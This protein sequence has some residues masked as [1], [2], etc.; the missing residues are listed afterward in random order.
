MD[1]ANDSINVAKRQ[2]RCRLRYDANQGVVDIVATAEEAADGINDD[3]NI[4]DE[5]ETNEN[6]VDNIVLQN[7]LVK[8]LS[9]KRLMSKT[10]LSSWKK[11]QMRKLK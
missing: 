5:N 8:S 7:P 1:V 3:E 9:L 10:T 11:S 2:K 4:M 6:V